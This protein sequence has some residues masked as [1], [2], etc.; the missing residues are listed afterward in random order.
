MS[1]FKLQNRSFLRLSGPDSMRYLNGQI[2]QKVESLN[3][4]SLWTA[5]TNAK[6]GIEGVGCVRQLKENEYLLDFP[7]ELGDLMEARLDRYLIADDCEWVREDERWDILVSEQNEF[8]CVS[9]RFRSEG[10][11]EK[12]EEATSQYSELPRELETE[13]C[14]RYGVPRWGY[15]IFGKELPAEVGL[16]E[17]ALS[18]DKGCYIGQEVISR[19]ETAGK[20]RKKLYQIKGRNLSVEDATTTCS[21]E[22]V[23]YV[24][25]F[26]KKDPSERFPNA[27]VR[28]F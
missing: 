2:T 21:Y 8:G 25:M 7:L 5:V 4:R 13:W 17:L 6:G 3:Q 14:A 16:Y 1:I 22:G 24:L 10:I 28:A 23:D 12:V 15:E 19:M 27:E 11:C 20:T 26:S 18:F 9:N